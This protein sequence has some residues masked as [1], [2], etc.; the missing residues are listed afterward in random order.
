MNATALGIASIFVVDW[1]FGFINR[2]VVQQ[3]CQQ[4]LCSFANRGTALVDTPGIRPIHELEIVCP[5]SVESNVSD[6]RLD[7]PGPFY[8]RG[9]SMLTPCLLVLSFAK[10]WIIMATVMFQNPPLSGRNG[11]SEFVRCTN[12]RGLAVDSMIFGL[13]VGKDVI[14]LEAEWHD[15]YN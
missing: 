13:I 12:R 5:W 1:S 7:T 6:E 10:A 8:A 15:C 9:W 2:W 11:C 14:A 3:I 4:P